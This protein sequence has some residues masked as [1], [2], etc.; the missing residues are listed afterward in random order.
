MD[1]KIDSNPSKKKDMFDDGLVY[2]YYSIM[3]DGW[4]R[5]HMWISDDELEE[6]RE[7]Y[8]IGLIFCDR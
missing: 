1:I 3:I 6:L 2:G 5:G 8:D 7:D 4:H